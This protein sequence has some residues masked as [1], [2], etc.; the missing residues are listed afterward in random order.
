MGLPRFSDEFL[1]FLHAVSEFSLGRD[2]QM[3]YRGQASRDYRLIPSLFRGIDMNTPHSVEIVSRLE[4]SLYFKFKDQGYQYIEQASGLELLAIMQHHHVPTRLLDWTH[5]FAVALYFAT[6][7]LNFE[8]GPHIWVLD[9]QELNFNAQGKR[10]VGHVNPGDY[11]NLMKA[12][13]AIPIWNTIAIQ[14]PL[15][16]DRIV[17][18]QGVFTLH[19]TRGTPLEE[20]VFGSQNEHSPNSILRKFDVPNCPIDI[21]MFL[22]LNGLTNKFLL[23]RGLDHLASELVNYKNTFIIRE[24]AKLNG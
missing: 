4:R 22:A 17:A 2:S 11:D 16:N 20:E 1:E 8:R 10:L 7:S 21:G 14:S 6:E 15:N 9:P 18:Q 5:S 24:M 3:W 23:F 19:A 13:G 12:E